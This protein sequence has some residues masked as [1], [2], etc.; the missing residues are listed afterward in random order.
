MLGAAWVNAVRCWEVCLE[1]LARR[2]NNY[3][4]AR[5]FKAGV[6]QAIAKFAEQGDVLSIKVTPVNSRTFSEV[7][8]PGWWV[9]RCSG[10][11]R[12]WVSR[13]SVITISMSPGSTS[14]NYGIPSSL[15]GEVRRQDCGHVRMIS[16]ELKLNWLNFLSQ[17]CA[18]SE[19]FSIGMWGEKFSIIL[20]GLKAMCI[21]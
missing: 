19:G 6:V 1:S 13:S 5:Q 11:V 8:L 4:L 12:R 7:G 10:V 2:S 3:G 14:T 20:A 17:I 21:S 15:T 16:Q 9:I 18:F